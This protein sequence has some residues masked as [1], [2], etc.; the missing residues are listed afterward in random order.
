MAAIDLNADVG[1][2]RGDD[3]ALLSVVTTA[4]VAAGGHAGGGDVMAR[5]VSQAVA[6]GVR[7]GAHPSYPDRAGFGRVSRLRDHDAASLRSSVRAQVWDV[8]QECADQGISLTHVKAHGALYHDVARD[9]G[10]AEA[11]ALAVADVA[12]DL[13][14][15]V[16]VLGPPSPLLQSAIDRRGIAYRIEAFTDRRYLADGSLAPRA[17]AGAVLHD[18]DVVVSQALSLALES[19]VV[20]ADGTAVSVRADSLC[21][22]GDTP[23]SVALARAVRRALEDAGVVVQ[24]PDES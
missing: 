13:G 14:T 16:F 21:V 4:N 8:G 18:P 2:E 15:A 1:E 24:H 6:Q 10:A 3:A 11:F 22:H 9:A 7:V 5:T 19:K 23:G 20:S 17:E 12:G